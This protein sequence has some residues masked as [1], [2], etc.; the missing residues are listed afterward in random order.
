[1]NCIVIIIVGTSIFFLI[2]K[3]SN[4]NL[5]LQLLQ[6]TTS[7]SHEPMLTNIVILEIVLVFVLIQLLNGFL[8]DQKLP[9]STKSDSR[10]LTISIFSVINL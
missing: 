6:P 7:F 8:R 1:V 3:Y 4:L 2:K 9:K 5:Q 10:F